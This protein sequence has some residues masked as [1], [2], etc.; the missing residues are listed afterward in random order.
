MDGLD[1]MKLYYDG[2]KDLRKQSKIIKAAL[3]GLFNFYC[4]VMT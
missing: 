1:L 2:N 3:I 4:V